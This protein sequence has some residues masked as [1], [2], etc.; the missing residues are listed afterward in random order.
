MSSRLPIYLYV[1]NILGYA[2]IAFGFLGLFYAFTSPP[3]TIALWITSSFLDLFDGVLARK[4]NQ[5][6][7]FGMILDIAA[8]N[9][10]RSI[11]W[12][13]AIISST[14]YHKENDASLSESSISSDNKHIWIALVATFIICLE[15]TTMLSTQLHACLADGKHWKKDRDNDP[16]FVKLYFSNNFRN[17]F[18]IVGVFGL[19]GSGIYTYASYIP[20]ISDNFPFFHYGRYISYVGRVIS[21]PVELWLCFTYFRAVISLE[22][23]KS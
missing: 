19:F 10:V 7:N 9:L 11:F 20:I 15:W 12:V 1:P 13:A 21:I 23:K 8:D 18:G 14:L 17:P 5:C 4:L 6:S 22:E 3:T 2:R 16:A